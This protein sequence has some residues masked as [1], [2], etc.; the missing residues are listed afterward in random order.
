MLSLYKVHWNHIFL[1][2][3]L[4][5]NWNLRGKSI[6]QGKSMYWNTI[7]LIFIRNTAWVSAFKDYEVIMSYL[8]RNVKKKKQDL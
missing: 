8:S 1:L 4:L 2:D 7:L 5:G 6:F 3:T